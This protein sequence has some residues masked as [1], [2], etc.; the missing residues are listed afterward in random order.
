MPTTARI[1]G[2]YQ[3]QFRND[4][5]LFV[6]DLVKPNDDV[7]KQILGLEYYPLEIPS[8]RLRTGIGKQEKM[9]I[10][11]LGFGLKMGN[12]EIDY[13]YTGSGEKDNPVRATLHRIAFSTK[14]G[15]LV[16]LSTKKLNQP[17][18]II[19]ESAG[20][21]SGTTTVR[22]AYMVIDP[23]TGTVKVNLFYEDAGSMNRC[24]TISGET[25]L[26]SSGCTN[27][28]Y[29]D[30]KTDYPEQETNIRIYIQTDDL[31]GATTSLY[32]ESFPLDIK[33]PSGKELV[34]VRQPAAGDSAI[35]IQSQWEDPAGSIDNI[36]SVQFAYRKNDTEEITW[37]DGLYY[38]G[39]TFNLTDSRA[40]P[41]D[42]N[43]YIN[44]IKAQAY[45]KYGNGPGVIENLIEKLVQ[46]AVP[47][48]P[49]VLAVYPSSITLVVNPGET[50]SSG[51]GLYYALRATYTYEN[52]DYG[53]W[54]DNNKNL[55][56]L[57]PVWQSLEPAGW[58]GPRVTVNGLEPG[59]T[60]Y[61]SVS[62]GNPRIG[63]EPFTGTVPE[64]SV[65]DYGTSTV[66]VTPIRE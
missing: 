37:Q 23:D 12:S 2:T 13:A 17:P 63:A 27:I 1:S 62:A 20:Q 30:A 50:I 43:D 51:K 64:N 34:F 60:Y 56:A 6:L 25:G 9:N 36:S 52:A 46:P 61:F 44:W 14:F 19:I 58:D 28:V 54:A 22:V 8:V 11:G 21:Q 42:G 5:F 18:K 7:W 33:A 53:K 47:G 35:T 24:K 3:F 55:S 57:S 26:V 32:S 48:S 38:Q 49:S 29:W 65:S 10:F 16:F 31:E 66:V 45:D 15:P 39:T 40:G 4:R 59:T 41:L